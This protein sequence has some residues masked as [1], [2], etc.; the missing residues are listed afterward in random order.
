MRGQL[1][2]DALE[3]PLARRR[4]TLKRIDPWSVLKFGFLANLT[5]LLILLVA[6]VVAWYF[7]RRLELVETICELAASVSIQE[8][9]VNGD[10]LFRVVAVLGLL[11]VVIATGIAVF[12]A[13]L[14]N[15]L[16]DLT[17]GIE[18][19]VEDDSPVPG[20]STTPRS[21]SGMPTGTTPTGGTPSGS[22]SSAGGSNTGSS[23]GSPPSATPTSSW[24]GD[25]LFGGDASGD[26]LFSDD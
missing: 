15:L 7:V 22:G 26:K 21:T 25:R 3:T 12:L 11:G 19:T 17:G 4:M 24:P 18:I 1:P 16:T 13:F 8:C 6:S 9:G 14:A 23:L 5:G 2:R 10:A 20:R